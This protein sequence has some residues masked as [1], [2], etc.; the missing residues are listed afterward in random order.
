MATMVVGC[1]SR[2]SCAGETFELG[3]PSRLGQPNDSSNAAEQDD[4]D[5]DADEEPAGVASDFVLLSFFVATTTSEKSTHGC[6]LMRSG[7]CCNF[8]V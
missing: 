4:T 5:G 3:S 1:H 7:F 2:L 6:S 8:G